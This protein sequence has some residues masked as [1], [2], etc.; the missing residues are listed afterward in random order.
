MCVQLGTTFVLQ[1][2]GFSAHPYMPGSGAGMVAAGTALAF[3]GGVL[4]GL[5]GSGGGA[6][7]SAASGSGATPTQ[8]NS[9]TS[10]RSTVGF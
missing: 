4:K 5:S 9:E 7:A 6:S 1:G 10:T 3:F 2:L 8:L